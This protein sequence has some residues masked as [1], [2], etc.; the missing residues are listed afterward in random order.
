M[1]NVFMKTIVPLLL[2]MIWLSGCA[3]S[4]SGKVYSRSQVQH[5]QV[6][7]TG[8]VLRVEAVLIEGTKSQIG[9]VAGGAI[10]GIAG[11]RS[12]RGTTGDVLGV[13]GA[14]VGG[15]AGAAAEEGITRR[16][17]LEI[18][19][20]LD[21]GQTLSVVQ[22]ADVPFARDDRVRILTGSDGTK[23]VGHL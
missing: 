1:M 21:S 6:V 7:D 17:G 12:S 16:K 2:L 20:K 18:T 22:E 13:L 5:A 3:S 4:H 23:R 19:I 11:G 14:V 10:G 9:T 15:I 8:V